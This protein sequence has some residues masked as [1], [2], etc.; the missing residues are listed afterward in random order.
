MKPKG[1]E[2]RLKVLKK[3][4][5]DDETGEKNQESCAISEHMSIVLE[6]EEES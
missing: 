4:K 6:M 1:H 5:T 3:G 2:W